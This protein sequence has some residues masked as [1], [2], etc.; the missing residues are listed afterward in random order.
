M[1]MY[2]RRADLVVEEAGEEV[3]LQG[4]DGEW[5]VLRGSA[6]ALWVA[7]GVPHTTGELVHALSEAYEGGPDQIASD[8]ESTL[9]E[10]SARNLV[11]TV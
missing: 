9:E 8:L 3:Y 6:K 4:H 5:L 1:T 11:V 7:L 2:Q 10:W